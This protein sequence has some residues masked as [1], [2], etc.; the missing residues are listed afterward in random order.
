VRN[1]GD[2]REE[3]GRVRNGIQVRWK[4]T[5]LLRSELGSAQRLL[6]K[7]EAKGRA[8]HGRKRGRFARKDIVW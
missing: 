3:S 1:Y 4:D 5:W 7:F 2:S 8:Q 6:K